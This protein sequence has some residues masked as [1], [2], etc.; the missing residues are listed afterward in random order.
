MVS[1]KKDM[2]KH[3]TI[4]YYSYLALGIIALVF[5]IYCLSAIF[6][7]NTL[8][9]GLLNI[10]PH[11]IAITLIL[12]LSGML[13][14]FASYKFLKSTRDSMT[15]GIA[16]CVSLALYPMYHT[17]FYRFDVGLLLILV[18]TIILLSYTVIHKK[19]KA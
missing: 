11:L 15:T 10:Y 14:L 8:I 1:S 17:V 5:A 12:L 16:G 3:K 6:D 19:N 9:K 4:F 13:L 7:T 18:P 2:K